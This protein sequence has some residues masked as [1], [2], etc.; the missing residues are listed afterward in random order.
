I[1]TSS[2]QKEIQSIF[3][4]SPLVARYGQAHSSDIGRTRLGRAKRPCES[5]W[6]RP[7]CYRGRFSRRKGVS[8]P[9]SQTCCALE[10]QESSA[11]FLH[12]CQ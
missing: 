1:I 10:L 2:A 8:R 5:R 3:P 4:Q 7:V 11:F 12:V 6:D 9:K